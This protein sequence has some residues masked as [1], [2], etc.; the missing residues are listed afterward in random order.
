MLIS[1]LFIHYEV[2]GRAGLCRKG[3]VGLVVPDPGCPV[4]ARAGLVK[5]GPV[6]LVVPGCPVVLLHPAGSVG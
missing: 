2:H 5:K 1:D 3:P 6:G 4:H